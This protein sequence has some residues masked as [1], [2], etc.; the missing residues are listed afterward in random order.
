MVVG[1]LALA[2]IPVFAGFF[3]KDEILS[4]AFARGYP[5]YWAVG[6]GVAFL[7]AFYSFRMIYMTFHGSW[8]GPAAV[9]K[10]VHESAPT[11]VAPL[12]ILAVPTAVAGLLLGIPP[13]GGVIHRWLEDVFAGAEELGTGIR[14]DSILGAALEHGEAHGFELVGLGGLLLLVGA[15][16]GV[17]GILLARRW[18]VHD[19]EAPARFVQ[20]FPF[21]L[22]PGMYRASVNKYYFDDL[23][24]LLFARGGVVLS[25]A[26]WWFD[27]KVI[28]GV[29]NGVGAAAQRLG[30][31]LRRS[32]TGRVQNYGLGIAAGLVIVLLVY[33]TVVR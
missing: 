31:G 9:W 4:E 26:L 30:S 18:Y 3:S 1:A 8:R 28:D 20:R 22:G 17:A 13:E 10:H 12:V 24:Q 21:G 16:V 23:Y 33:A 5:I 32:Q 19:P 2:G 7:T 25:N 11:I 14:P 27:V 29:V 15:A 6:I